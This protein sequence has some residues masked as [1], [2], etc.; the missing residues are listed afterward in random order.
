MDAFIEHLPC[1]TYSAMRWGYSD[2]KRCLSPWS[3]WGRQ[4]WDRWA[5]TCVVAKQ[6]SL[7]F[8]WVREGATGPWGLAVP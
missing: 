7:F 2:Q 5:S 8:C 6:E 3:Q 4:I 1:V